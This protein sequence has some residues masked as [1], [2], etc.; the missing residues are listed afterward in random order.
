MA[1][2][3][4]IGNGFD[5]AAELPTKYAHFKRWLEEKGKN[6]AE[7]L[8]LIEKLSKDYGF[9]HI[10]DRILEKISY[11]DFEEFCPVEKENEGLLS[12]AAGVAEEWTKCTNGKIEITGMGKDGILTSLEKAQCV[13]LLK[14]FKEMGDEEWTQESMDKAIERIAN[15]EFKFDA[16]K[17]WIHSNMLN[18]EDITDEDVA[19]IIIA[20][21]DDKAKSDWSDFEDALGKFE[22]DLLTEVQKTDETED[23]DVSEISKSLYY[24]ILM[25]ILPKVTA[26]FEKWIETINVN[27]GVVKENF[28]SKMDKEKD[29]FLNFNFTDTLE[30]LYGVKK[31]NVCHI[32]GIRTQ[33]IVIGHGRKDTDFSTEA[34][35]TWARGFKK[36]TNTCIINNKI[37]FS[38]LK[39]I[40]EIYS[41]GFSFAEVDMPY[42]KEIFQNIEAKE[43]TWYL[44]K[45]DENNGN[46]KTFRKK[47][48]EV[49][50]E[51]GKNCPKYN[52]FEM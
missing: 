14:V 41:I 16:I 40:T 29:I 46:N 25:N 34:P 31:E 20:A 26:F 47:I 5:V 42:I 22:L 10:I 17:E 45:F 6:N 30:S 38:S 2:L 35:D 11:M 21:I 12:F 9:K 50:K 27:K 7:K 8:R 49:A 3:F 4:I 32:H 36:N 33:N 15:K 39:D 44:T 52:I 19:D 24:L 37:F 18:P 1:K 51:Q 23:D 28:S 43:V 48:D 13:N